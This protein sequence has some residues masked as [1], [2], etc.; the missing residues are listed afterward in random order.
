MIVLRVFHTAFEILILLVRF[1]D[2]LISWYKDEMMVLVLAL[3]RGWYWIV[4]LI[5]Q[6]LDCFL[7]RSSLL[8]DIIFQDYSALGKWEMVVVIV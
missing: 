8:E 2:V 1:I 6:V 5:R 3:I 4:L 7:S